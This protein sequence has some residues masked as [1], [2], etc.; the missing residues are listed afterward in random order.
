MSLLVP[1]TLKI[2]VTKKV[3]HQSTVNHIRIGLN[4][5][6]SLALA[7]QEGPTRHI[8]D[9]FFPFLS[10]VAKTLLCLSWLIRWETTSLEE[11]CCTSNSS[12]YL[13][14]LQRYP[15]QVRYEYALIAFW[16]RQDTSK[17][18]SY[19]LTTGQ[20]HASMHPLTDLLQIGQF[21]GPRFWVT[22]TPVYS[23]EIL[24]EIWGNPMTTCLKVTGTQWKLVW[25]FSSRHYFKS[26]FLRPWTVPSGNTHILDAPNFYQKGPIKRALYPIIRA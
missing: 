12:Q 9:Y 14:R 5:V 13:V 26:D 2:C 18:P 17:I 15:E 10:W 7:R 25:N 3:D 6:Q 21:S 19:S 24:F 20:S 11:Y 1:A 16:N 22:G 4:Q 8:N 23:V